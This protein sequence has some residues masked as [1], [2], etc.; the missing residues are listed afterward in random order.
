MNGD[1]KNL[2]LYLGNVPSN[3]PEVILVLLQSELCSY[4]ILHNKELQP[5]VQTETELLDSFARERHHLYRR[6]RKS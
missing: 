6:A 2:L 4:Q 3:A 1:R 5:R